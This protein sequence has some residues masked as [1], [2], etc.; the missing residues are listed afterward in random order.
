MWPFSRRQKNLASLPPILSDA[1]TWG[2]AEADSN[3]SPLLIRFNSSAQDWVGHTALGIRLGFAVPL[4]APN[5]GGM[6][7]GDENRQLNDIEDV[8]LREVDAR[9]KGIP[10]FVLTNG[11]MKEFVF[12]IT[13]DTDIAALHEAIRNSVSTHEVQCMAVKDPDWGAYREFAPF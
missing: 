6:P 10:A 3:G 5:E 7:G 8:I 2:M 11:I 4:N 9:A 1:H 13:A 12:Y